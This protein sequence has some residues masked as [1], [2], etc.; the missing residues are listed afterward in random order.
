MVPFLR[1]ANGLDRRRPLIEVD[2]FP[3]RTRK[4]FELIAIFIRFAVSAALIL[5]IYLWASLVAV[6]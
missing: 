2:L 3:G 5:S 4:Y 1:R 6:I